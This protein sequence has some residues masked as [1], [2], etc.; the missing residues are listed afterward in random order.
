VAEGV[1]RETKAKAE[2]E[3]EDDLRRGRSTTSG[4]T[5]CGKEHHLRQQTLRHNGTSRHGSHDK[6]R[7]QP[8]GKPTPK[9]RRERGSRKE[10]AKKVEKA[11]V[12]SGRNP[13]H[14]RAVTVLS[15]NRVDTPPRLR[16][17]SSR[18]GTSRLGLFKDH[19]PQSGR[20]QSQPQHQQP[21]P[22]P[23]LCWE[24]PPQTVCGP[25]LWEDTQMMG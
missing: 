21:S 12:I 24:D 23:L 18:E 15:P 10:Q 13:A 19:L 17:A 6:T 25:P 7:E 3:A 16:S 22:L 9:E 14:A 2:A 1:Q 20:H 5:A 4:E 11:P 8:K